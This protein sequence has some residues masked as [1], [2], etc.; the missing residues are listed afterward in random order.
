MK[1]SAK[2]AAF[3]KVGLERLEDRRLLSASDA[4]TMELIQF[5]PETTRVVEAE[6][7]RMNLG[8]SYDID[9]RYRTS[10]SSAQRAAFDAAVA[11]W[12]T[13][14]L[15][16][17]PNVND[18]GTTIDDLVIDVY[19]RQIDGPG[20]VL[21]SAGP[22]GVRGGSLLP[23]EGFMEFDS[24]D[25]ANL[26][27][28]GTLDE[29]ILHEMGHVLGIGTLWQ[30]KGLLVGTANNPRF[31]GSNANQAYNQTRTSNDSQGAYVEAD[32]GGGTA[33]G[34][35]DEG[36]YNSELM[37][38]FVEPANVAMQLSRITAGSLIDLGYPQVNL[39]AADAYTLPTNSLISN[40]RNDLPQINGL[41]LLPANLTGGD[42]T[43]DIS[44][45]TDGSGT[46][47]VSFFL[48]TNGIPGLQSSTYNP[49]FANPDQLLA[50]DTNSAGGWRVV[51]PNSS[52]PEGEFTIY[53]RGTD[54]RGLPTRVLTAT[55]FK[56]AGD[57]VAPTVTA[58]NFSVATAQPSVSFSF[59]ED[60]AASV[61]ASDLILF[62]TTTGTQVP[63][64][65]LTLSYNG[66]SNTATF[67]INPSAL[68]N[69]R[70]VA[71][72]PAGSVQDAAGNSLA[73]NYNYN[74]SFINGDINQDLS[75][76][77]NDFFILR[78]NFNMSGATFSDGDLNFDGLINLSDFF[79]LRAN[80][81]YQFPSPDP[82]G[83][84]AGDDDEGLFG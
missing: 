72:L 34:H 7:T 3:A 51:V 26:L 47:E 83:D 1:H 63:S 54:N 22:T 61:S 37:T 28:N 36:V 55:G 32:G 11:R 25:A 48:D 66:V 44:S 20:G 79:I 46:N 39:D 84:G 2:Q 68:T 74:F 5:D 62:N 43:I 73:S 13:V 6:S 75:V 9:L 15:G 53:A 65:N 67:L 35:W 82:S 30:P 57:T 21:G 42:L 40:V 60:V 19:F 58:A 38:G 49:S 56:T 52:I 29:V 45:F 76:N 17:L 18:G 16:D 24:A 78:S 71:T 70:W 10:A 50:S 69:G 77:L 27:N 59:S 33:Y 31:A 4:G 12:E 81:N 41:T 64:S 14:L 80:F 23:F 8:G